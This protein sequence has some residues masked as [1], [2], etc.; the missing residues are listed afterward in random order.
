VYEY[1][2]ENTT[3]DLPKKISESQVTSTIER[4]RMELLYRG[5]D[6][7][8]VEKRLAE[9]RAQTEEQA[10]N[11]LKLLFV[12]NKVA[13]DFSIEVN[14]NEINGRIAMIA[15]QKGE[16][17]EKVREEL[18]QSGAINEVARQIAEHK[19]ADRIVDQAAVTEI[20][21]EEWNEI[22]QSKAAGGSTPSKKSSSKKKASGKK[23]PS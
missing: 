4:Q 9:I 15:R 11:R 13:R 6:P 5:E 10:L 8:S 19:A 12:M 14:E 18:T 3:M 2:L 20:P 7:E 21:A 17:P 1:L 23:K 22:A 16:R